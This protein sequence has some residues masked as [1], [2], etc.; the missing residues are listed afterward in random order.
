MLL[1]HL[2]SCW[3]MSSSGFTD[4][5]CG[6]KAFDYHSEAIHSSTPPCPLLQSQIFVCLY[7]LSIEAQ[8]A[9]DQAFIDEVVS[10]IS[11]PAVLIPLPV[12]AVCSWI[13]SC[14]HSGKQEWPRQHK[15]PCR[16]W[17]HPFSCLTHFSSL[18]VNSVVSEEKQLQRCGAC[19]GQLCHCL[20]CPPCVESVSHCSSPP[21][22][23]TR[24]VLSS[25]L[26][27]YSPWFFV[28]WWQTECKFSRCWHLFKRCCGFLYKLMSSVSLSR[29]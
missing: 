10:S 27:T 12:P 3:V 6:A 21:S 7:S 11:A 5:S 23:S 29:A 18:P 22:H 26:W 13:S 17:L 14:H 9:S 20:F 16:F 19:W 1:H 2:V 25:L 28:N 24:N 8:A 15:L 4:T